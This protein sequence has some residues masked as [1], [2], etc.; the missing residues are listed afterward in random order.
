LDARQPGIVAIHSIHYVTVSY[1]VLIEWLN[2]WWWD[3][4]RGGYHL[5]GRRGRRGRR[6][7][8]YDVIFGGR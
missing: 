5:R 2:G 7:E 3:D 1:L 4:R 6:E 8:D